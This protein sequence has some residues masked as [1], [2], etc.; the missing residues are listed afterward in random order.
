[1]RFFS[2]FP[3][4]DLELLNSRES[5]LKDTIKSVVIFFIFLSSHKKGEVIGGHHPIK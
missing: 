5:F 3:Q 1:M 2:H 4:K